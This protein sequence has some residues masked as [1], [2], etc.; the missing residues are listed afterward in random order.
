MQKKIVFLVIVSMLF[1][2]TAFGIST[3]NLNATNDGI[4][5]PIW[6]VGDYWKYDVEFS[7]SMGD[8]AEFDLFISGLTFTVE[9]VLTDKYKI[10]VHVPSGGITGQGTVTVGPIDIS[11]SISNAYLDGTMYIDKPTLAI[12]NNEG[13][14]PVLTF[15]GNLGR[16]SIQADIDIEL[17]NAFSSLSFPLDVGSE[18]VVPYNIFTIHYDAQVGLLNINDRS[19][20]DDMFYPLWLVLDEHNMTCVEKNDVAVAFGTYK[21]SYKI[22]WADDPNQYIWYS[23]DAKNI[24]KVNFVN[25]N[26]YVLFEKFTMELVDSS[27]EPPNDPPETPDT[28]SGET[29]GYAYVKYE[30]STSSTDP[31]SHQ[32]KYGFNWGDGSE[33]TWTGFVNSGQ[34]IGQEHMYTSQGTYEIKVQAEDEKG[35]QSNWSDSLVVTINPNNHPEKPEKPDGTI[36]GGKGK[37]Y[38]Y[39]STTTDSDDDKIYYIFD[40]GDG[41][42]SGWLGPYNSDVEVSASHSWSSKGNYQIKVK[43]K[44]EHGA[45]SDW[46]DPLGVS[47]PKSVNRLFIFSKLISQFPILEKLLAII[48]N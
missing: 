2:N 16:K 19:S 13:Y 20:E 48:L 4:E 10:D 40:W 27:Y 24:V 7:G 31:N 33:I 32:I 45:E 8:T 5:V 47:M 42:T 11:G 3:V 43:A 41:K 25:L 17:S 14:L 28:P 35:A 36:D 44:D 38:T 6:N 9:Q 23:P 29:N 46:S 15:A 39:N 1:V 12:S 26:L 22:E 37:T 21:D 30:Y 34:T 18:W